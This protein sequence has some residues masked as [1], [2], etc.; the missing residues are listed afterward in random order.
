MAAFAPPARRGDFIY[1]SVLQADPGNSIPHPRASVAELAALLRPEAPNLYS[2]GRKPD[3]STPAKDPPWH[4]YAAQL[5]HYGLPITKDK[6]R[7]KLKLLDAMNQFKLEVPAWVLKLEGELRNEW[8]AENRKMRKGAGGG[9]L[10]K[11]ANGYQDGG[12]AKTETAQSA[13]AGVNVT[14]KQLP[15]NDE[16][17]LMRAQSIYLSPLVSP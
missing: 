2:K 10:G 9:K 8:D 3:F 12:K 1:S 7:A 5:I 15:Y 6:S 4:F 13:G 17:N 16:P 14:G 11:G